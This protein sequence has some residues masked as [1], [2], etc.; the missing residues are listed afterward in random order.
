MSAAMGKPHFAR[1][2]RSNVRPIRPSPWLGLRDFALADFGSNQIDRLTAAMHGE[3]TAAG[4]Y[5]DEASAML[6]TW[7][8]AYFRQPGLRLFFVVPRAWTDRILPLRVSQPCE[9]SG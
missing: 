1:Y 8:Q 7:R 9:S 4:L 6:A 5:E 2:R 3:L